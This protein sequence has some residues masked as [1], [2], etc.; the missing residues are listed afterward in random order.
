MIDAV[1]VDDEIL[2]L[3]LLKRLLTERGSVNIIGEFTDPA[4]ALDKIPGLKPDVLFLD[5]E[6]PEM[7]GIELGTK[8]LEY[9]NEMDIVFV[10]AYEQYAIQAFKLNALHYILKPADEES[11]D[12]TLQRILKK[13][14][15]N[16]IAVGYG[17]RIYM[18]GDVCVLDGD[19][20]RIKW[21][22]SKVEELFVLLLLNREKG[23]SKW[24]IIE[25]L[26]EEADTKKSQ[27]NLYTTIFRLKKTL[28]DAGIKA[29]IEN[30][31]GNYRIILKEVFCDLFEFEDFIKIRPE[32][33]ED[34]LPAFERTISLYREDLLGISAYPWSVATRESCY[35][36]YVDL[37]KRTAACYA[38]NGY[39][40]RLKNLYKKARFL[41]QEEDL[42][43]IKTIIATKI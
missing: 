23:I 27:Q 6:M 18:F 11:I 3:N 5:V 29:D 16:G 14:R 28:R 34:T 20:N 13:K 41:L 8:L 1:I 15:Q 10:T 30:N 35:Y 39:A 17:G 21:S 2:V 32:A 33:N 9:D 36:N 38:R 24:R 22:T 7:N 26:W 42:F 4:I 37:V 25:F 43:D 19:N 31:A 12:E 40:D